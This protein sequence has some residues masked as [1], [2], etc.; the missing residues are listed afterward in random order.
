MAFILIHTR[1]NKPSPTSALTVPPTAPVQQFKFTKTN[2]ISSSLTSKSRGIYKIYAITPIERLDIV[3]RN[4]REYFQ[5]SK[6]WITISSDL[7]QSK[8][9]EFQTTANADG[10]KISEYIQPPKMT[11]SKK[12]PTI[13]GNSNPVL[14]DAQSLATALSSLS[15]TTPNTEDTSRDTMPISAPASVETNILSSSYWKNT[16]AFKKLT[17]KETQIQYYKRLNSSEEVLKLVVLESKPFGSACEIIIQELFQLGP[18]TS[19]Q[20]DATRNGKKIEIK[21]ARYWSCKDEC[22]WQHL[23]MEHDYEY[24]LFVLVDFKMLKVWIIKKSVLMGDLQ[25]AKVVTYQGKQGW[26]TKKSAILKYLTPISTIA[27]LDE[28]IQ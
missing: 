28:F 13:T 18:R 7:F 2:D 4:I 19:S 12:I 23:E 26:W 16:T 14:D 17:E 5:I 25:K 15:L 27:E 1:K 10:I 20:N 11:T 24:V 21:S 8:W 9:I 6:K 22:V 3:E